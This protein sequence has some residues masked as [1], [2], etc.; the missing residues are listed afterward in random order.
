MSTMIITSVDSL[1]SL[2]CTPSFPEHISFGQW[3]LSIGLEL[4]LLYRQSGLVLIHIAFALKNF[5]IACNVKW[6]LVEVVI[7]TKVRV[8]NFR[9]HDVITVVFKSFDGKQARFSY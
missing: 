7:S 3:P 8:E 1:E 2:F 4:L 9:E 5:T 6:V